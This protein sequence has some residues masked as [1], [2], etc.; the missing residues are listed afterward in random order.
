MKLQLNQNTFTIEKIP[1]KA[2]SQGSGFFSIFQPFY[3]TR[4][5]AIL[6]RKIFISFSQSTFVGVGM[7][8][9][10]FLKQSTV[11][12]KYQYFFPNPHFCSEKE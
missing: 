9:E 11:L 1:K 4:Q 8:T 7:H 5:M 12:K 6:N 3:Y 2:R 10:N